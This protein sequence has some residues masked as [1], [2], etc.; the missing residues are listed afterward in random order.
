MSNIFLKSIF[1]CAAVLTSSALNAKADPP[2]PFTLGPVTFG[3]FIDSYYAND[4]DHADVITHPYLTQP[5]HDNQIGI[6]LAYLDA[7]LATDNFRGR[8][9]AQAGS[10]VDVNYA[11]EHEQGWRYVQEATLGYK[12]TN[13]LWIDGGIYLSHIGFETFNSKDNWNYTRSLVADYSPYY[14]TGVKLSYQFNPNLTGQ[15]HV[16]RGWQN[17]SNDSD[18]A[19]GMQL[20]Y[21]LS[22]ATQL[23]YNNFIGNENG[24]RIF[25][26]FIAKTALTDQFNVAAQVDVGRQV[27]NYERGDAWWWGTA[28]MAQYK[29]TPKIALAGRAEYFNDPHQAI[30]S[31]VTDRHFDASGLSANIDFEIFKNLLWRNEFRVLLGQHDIFLGDKDNTDQDKFFVTS[32]SYSF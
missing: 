3:G 18:P 27:Q 4:Y 31:S 29:I 2:P 6:N 10:S 21:A 15:L 17:I 25:H 19:L 1:L 30:I 24:S 14:E 12:L 28:L 22:K 9:A 23:T 16:L 32:L 7:K 11:A 8:L 13:D 5:V 20:S 26:D